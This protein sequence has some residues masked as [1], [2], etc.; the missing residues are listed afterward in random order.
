MVGG[1]P[2]V[3]TAAADGA[4]L[5]AD[6]SSLAARQYTLT[7]FGEARSEVAATLEEPLVIVPPAPPAAPESPATP[8]GTPA[9]K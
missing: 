7:L 3:L 1:E 6:L 8:G 5:S 2:A 4:A 9:P